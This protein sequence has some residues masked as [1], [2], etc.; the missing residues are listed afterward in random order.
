MS[1][2]LWLLLI[3]YVL[4]SGFCK[5]G[6][7]LSGSLNRGSEIAASV[8]AILMRIRIELCIEGRCGLMCEVI[9]LKSTAWLRGLTRSRPFFAS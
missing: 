2:R 9:I 6:L 1:R 5:P 3:N 4:S 8:V 7:Q